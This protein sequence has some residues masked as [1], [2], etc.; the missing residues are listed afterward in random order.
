MR[1]P[2]FNASQTVRAIVIA[3]AAWGI[4]LLPY[5]SSVSADDSLLKIF[6]DSGATSTS[7]FSFTSTNETDLA[8]S[9]W[10]FGVNE[11]DVYHAAL[12]HRSTSGVSDHDWDIRVGKGGQIYSIRGEVG[13]IVPPQSRSRPFVDE[14][15]QSISVDRSLQQTGGQPA[16]YHQSGYYRDGNNVN[17]PTYSPLL[18]SGAVDA[19]SY[20]TLS[21]AVQA[22]TES[23]P[24]Q[25][26]GL[27]N[28]QRT[29]DL[30]GGVIEVTHSIYNFGNHT[31]DFHNLPWG[32]VRKT[33]FDNMLVSNPNGGFT[34]RTI[35]GFGD[36]EN[37]VE[38]VQN[39]GGWAAFAEGA[40]GNDQG[41][42][43]VFGDT[44]THLNQD[45]QSERSSWRWG[46][47]G[48][49]VLGFPLRDFNVGTF[50]RFVDVDPGDLFESRYFMVL[51]DVDHI[52]ST[53]ED[54]SLVDL[55]I[56][57]KIIFDES[58]SE[59]LSYRVVT[60]NDSI[61]VLGA[62]GSMD[63]DFKTLARPV[64]GSLP[65]L[66][67]SDA[68][69]RQF[70]SVDPYALSDFP[71]DGE[72]TYEGLLGFVLPEDI[73]NAD[74]PYV[75]LTTLFSSDFYLDTNPSVSIFALQGSAAVPEPSGV[76]L[77]LLGSCCC[78]L[79]RR[80]HR[81]SLINSTRIASASS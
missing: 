1:I 20:S 51:G 25:P 41:I 19:N 29:R 42:A 71:Y 43:Y 34:D 55:A 28:Y 50:R 69:G 65:L 7:D 33:K 17:Q 18:A 46:D 80:K 37:Q 70:L 23:N 57:N 36:F 39:T 52:Q 13:E 47:G 72:T 62:T 54:R 49:D 2:L 21:L 74:G 4:G 75:D 32:G 24:Q 40:N 14:V 77:I 15:F 48:G 26:G 5:A 9:T 53:I 73:A 45:W 22:D 79:I 64:H 61:S 30:G 78:S 38:L 68:E 16:F 63:S 35:L 11:N 59:Q 66:L 58:D 76:V 6:S 3:F 10:G 67:F 27:L 31:V 60:D 81:H 56:Y 12:K 44:D 8:G